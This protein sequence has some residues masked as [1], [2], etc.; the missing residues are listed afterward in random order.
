MAKEEEEESERTVQKRSSEDAARES[1]CCALPR[2]GR[3]SWIGEL[4]LL[5]FWRIDC[6]YDYQLPHSDDAAVTGQR[7]E[8]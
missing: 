2:L 7:L 6:H 5:T 1:N 4:Q 8:I 3:G